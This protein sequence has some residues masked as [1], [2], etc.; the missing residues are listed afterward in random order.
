MK[1]LLFCTSL[2]ENDSLNKYSE[3]W[4]YY[5]QRFPEFD[6][7]ILNDG[8]VEESIFNNLKNLTGDDF[9]NNNLITF[10]NRLV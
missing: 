4:K 6:F 2:L 8:P 1:T 3:W 7:M 5:K 10:D 9:S